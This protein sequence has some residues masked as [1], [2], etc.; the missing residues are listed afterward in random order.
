MDNIS[1]EPA[2]KKSNNNQIVDEVIGLNDSTSPQSGQYVF[3]RVNKIED[4]FCKVD[5]IAVGEVPV[6]TVF[7]GIIL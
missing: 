7:V 6:T 5:I 4:R 2:I 1:V 3:A